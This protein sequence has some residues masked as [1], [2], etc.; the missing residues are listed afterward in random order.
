MKKTSFK[1]LTSVLVLSLILTSCQDA[2]VKEDKEIKAAP[3]ESVSA[4]DTQTEESTSSEDTEP[5]PKVFDD[6]LIGSFLDE[7]AEFL[8]PVTNTSIE[9]HYSVP[10]LLSESDDAKRINSEIKKL[11]GDAAEASL[12][13]IKKNTE[14]VLRKISYRTSW[15]GSVVSLVIECESPY[16][17][18]K[19]AVYN[20]DFESEKEV[21]AKEMLSHLGVNEENFLYR[22]GSE[23]LS[24][25]SEKFTGEE[26]RAAVI[27]KNNLNLNNIDVYLDNGVLTARVL[28]GS[29]GDG[30]FYNS[31]IEL[32]APEVNETIKEETLGLT[33]AKLEN[34]KITLTFNSLE[35]YK[36]LA[37]PLLK[38]GEAYEVK[39]LFGNIQDFYL[40]R[41]KKLPCL[42]I[43]DDMGKVSFCDISASAKSGTEFIAY[44]ALPQI[45][46]IVSF[47]ESDTVYAIDAEGES[48]D[49]LSAALEKENW[50][51]EEMNFYTVW[52]TEDQKYR[53]TFFPEGET[54]VPVLFENSED[55]YFCEGSFFYAGI[56]EDGCSFPMTFHNDDGSLGG[57]LLTIPYEPAEKRY[58]DN[59]F[60]VSFTLNEETP[61]LPANGTSIK[62]TQYLAMDGTSPHT[63]T[64]KH[65][66]GS[67][68]S[69]DGLT[70]L[71]LNDG[72]SAVYEVREPDGTVKTHCE[73]TWRKK[74]FDI[75]TLSLKCADD[76]D[77]EKSLDGS[78]D[79]IKGLEGSLVLIP[80]DG[81]F[82]LTDIQKMNKHL[83]EIF[84]SEGAERVP[85]EEAENGED[86]KKAVI[87]CAQST[88][89]KANTAEIIAD[90]DTGLLVRAFYKDES[91]ERTKAWYIVDPETMS[92]KNM[93]NKQSVDFKSYL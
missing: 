71:K 48:F 93:G 15:S 11:I 60:Y 50:R 2:P 73:G 31:Y 69:T 38:S 64:L 62:F 83:P 53:I 29:T 91:G 36:D 21:S 34:N 80:H 35:Q 65:L 26:N 88:G 67:W 37:S 44:N 3:A 90:T 24:D 85:Y 55:G 76:E 27:S 7:K 86:I 84:Y 32:T 23:A 45:E 28:I 33:T 57:G 1:T 30:G 47:K 41:N 68:L 40:S 54:G 20:F 70:S 72:N 92:G 46:N 5:A 87:A 9:C 81:A 6:S 4:S 56:T 82:P 66:R 75:L 52:T 61:S 12:A 10:K 79:Y 89:I 39:G 49:V 19:R 78:Y 63:S 13:E 18:M 58:G 16:D 59:D 22:L 51:A 77:E 17:S 14:P 74:D 8:H 25:F 42:F 43:L